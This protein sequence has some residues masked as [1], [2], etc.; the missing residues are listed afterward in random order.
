MIRCFTIR[1]RHSDSWGLQYRWGRSPKVYPS[2]SEGR[3]FIL[4]CV[5]NHWQQQPAAESKCCAQN[6]APIP[7]ATTPHNRLH[8]IRQRI[9]DVR[10][11]I[12]TTFAYWHKYRANFISL[13]AN[14]NPE[15]VRER[16]GVLILAQPLAPGTVIVWSSCNLFM[17]LWSK[18][19][20]KRAR[21]KTRTLRL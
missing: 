1:L 6:E 16:S 3:W 4:V 8:Y 13:Y 19:G 18:A 14:R 7:L 21:I 10:Q 2:I 5:C 12:S 11:H 15:W 20:L 17:L 9:D